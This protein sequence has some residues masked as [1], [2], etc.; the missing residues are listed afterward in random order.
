MKPL[1]I[2][3]I[4]KILFLLF[5]TNTEIQ[6]AAMV[7]A[8][9]A[10]EELAALAVMGAATIH[11]MLVQYGQLNKGEDEVL[12]VNIP[13]T[14]IPTKSIPVTGKSNEEVVTEVTQAVTTA[15]GTKHNLSTA[16]QNKLDNQLRSQKLGFINTIAHNRSWKQAQHRFIG[17][18]ATIGAIKNCNSQKGQILGNQAVDIFILKNILAHLPENLPGFQKDI[19]TIQRTFIDCNS[20]NLVRKIEAR[21]QLSN[22]VKFDPDLFGDIR[23]VACN[24][25]ARYFDKDKLVDIFYDRRLAETMW[26]LLRDFPFYWGEKE[27]KKFV[28]IIKRDNL[29]LKGGFERLYRR[30]SF[31]LSA[32][33][34][35][36]NKEYK[37]IAK[38]GKGR[39]F[40]HDRHK[41]I[42]NE[43][44]NRKLFEIATLC[45]QGGFEQALSVANRF[46]SSSTIKNSMMNVIDHY[47]QDPISLTPDFDSPSTEQPISDIAPPPLPPD[48][49]PDR[50]KEQEQD[51]PPEE[52]NEFSDQEAKLKHNWAKR[53]GHLEKTPENEKLIYDV[54]NDPEYYCGSPDEYGNHWYAKILKNGR[55][56]WARVRDNKIVGW[57]INKAKD[58]RK[59]N[60]KTGLAALKTPSQK[61]AKP[62]SEI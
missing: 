42:L 35:R 1:F 18:H 46:R 34:K 31:Q 12:L 36:Q 16:D 5:V 30:I 58:I 38:L 57:G 41:Q 47:R 26:I 11:E 44:Y 56:V 48:Q 10:T 27:L 54:A 8:A 6:P 7:T 50:D 59:W 37:P 23:E 9:M 20:P 53:K 51:V 33:E 39:F 61:I 40:T 13:K 3:Y 25:Q 55:Q 52:K 60:S 62:P 19:Q 21:I 17:H 22:L 32:K 14:S 15:I 29:D 2:S 43:S 49:D 4:S 24:L 45:E 28:G